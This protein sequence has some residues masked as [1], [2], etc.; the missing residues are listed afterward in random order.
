MAS[1][2][3]S[4]PLKRLLHKKTPQDG[5][6]TRRTTS[7]AAWRLSFD[8]HDGFY[9]LRIA[10]EVRDYFTVDVRGKLIAKLDYRWGGH[11]HLFAFVAS[12]RPSFATFGQQTQRASPSCPTDA[13][14]PQEKAMERREAVTARLRL[15]ILRLFRT[16]NTPSPRTP[17]QAPRSTRT[18]SPP[19]QRLLEAYTV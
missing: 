4:T 15:S 9:T 10:L 17:R 1:N 2:M 16:R 5:N 12:R 19:N 6:T 8:M 13:T 7:N 11:S 3:R 14:L 18:T